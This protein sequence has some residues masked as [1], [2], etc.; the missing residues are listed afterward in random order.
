M[1]T[2][3]QSYT[4]L[5]SWRARAAGDLGVML[6]E[7]WAYV[8]DVTAFYD[9]RIAE[10]AYLLTAPDQA[11]ARR[12]TAM[13]GHRARPA[14]AAS[15]KVAVEAE[16]SDPLSL[17]RGT[18]FRS[19]A[20]GK[21]PPQVFEL[22]AKTKIWPQRNRWELAPV[23]ETTLGPFD[24]TLRFL[25]G[26]GPSKGDIILLW[27][28]ADAN[29]VSAAR[30]AAVETESAIDGAQYLRATLERVYAS[31]MDCL[32]LQ[33]RRDIKVAV[34]RLALHENPRTVPN[35]SSYRSEM[36]LN[37]LYP[38]VQ[39][40]TRAVVDSG[41][42]LKPVK[43]TSVGKHPLTLVAAS[44]SPPMPATTMDVTQVHWTPSVSWTANTSFALHV[45]RI[46][47]ASLK[48]LLKAKNRLS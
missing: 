36:K 26:R 9:A 15:V 4:A 42:T 41:G 1:L 48:N 45:D 19:E 30:V 17:A 43:I 24:G 21:E 18:A 25:P 13:I 20:F 7:C 22:A 47:S 29:T 34:A 28:Q 35:T 31:G 39:P 33:T 44:N 2:A 46:L 14:M 37:A 16:G 12:L 38:Q 5:G 23:R 10:R 32:T 27:H 3:I 8:L 11:A 6:L 40:N